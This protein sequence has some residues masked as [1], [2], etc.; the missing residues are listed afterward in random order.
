MAMI[1][2]CYVVERTTSHADADLSFSREEA[3]ARLKQNP[4]N[5]AVLTPNAAL[6]EY[7]GI[8]ERMDRVALDPLFGFHG[9]MR[10]ASGHKSI[11]PS[12][13]VRTTGRRHAGR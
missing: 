8:D 13:R 2:G 10:W 4:K 9:G 6:K 3:E 1:S 7:A 11:T 12:F 5:P